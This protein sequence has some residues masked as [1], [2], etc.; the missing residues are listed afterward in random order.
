M[1]INLHI[2]R[3]VLDGVNIAPGQHHVPQTSVETELTRLLAEGGVSPPS[4]A[5]AVRWP[6]SPA[7]RFNSTVVM[8]QP[9]L[10]GRSPGRFTEGS[11]NEQVVRPNRVTQRIGIAEIRRHDQAGSAPKRTE[12]KEKTC[13]APL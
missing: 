6:A 11:Q 8:D 9:S 7:Q 5:A 3:L 13:Q 1:N 12:R 4:Q 10:D 2:E